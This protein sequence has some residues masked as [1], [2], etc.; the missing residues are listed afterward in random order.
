MMN[1]TC[2]FV[3]PT[4]AAMAI[5]ALT[6]GCGSVPSTSGSTADFASASAEVVEYTPAGKT[7]RTIRPT[8]SR[9]PVRVCKTSAEWE[10]E[11][12][13]AQEAIKRVQRDQ[14]ISA[15]EDGD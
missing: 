11:E 4:L 14:S 1:D 13:E 7:C 12:A 10:R 5:L 8:G 2:L 3:R 15:G 6:A 9:I